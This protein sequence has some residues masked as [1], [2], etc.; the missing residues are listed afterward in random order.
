MSTPPRYIALHNLSES[1][2]NLLALL[3][4]QKK[5]PQKQLGR[6]QQHAKQFFKVDAKTD[7]HGTSRAVGR[8]G[9][10]SVTSVWLLFGNALVGIRIVRMACC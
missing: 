9:T 5:W 2:A 10:Y 7:N 1:Q 6:I 3:A 8:C 4:T